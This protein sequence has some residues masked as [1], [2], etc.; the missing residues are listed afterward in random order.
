MD[1]KEKALQMGCSESNIYNRVR[2]NPNWE[3]A[4][5]VGNKITFPDSS[6]VT[7][8]SEPDELPTEEYSK[9]RKAFWDAENSKQNTIKQLRINDAESGR[10]VK[11]SELEKG[12]GA[13]LADIR[14]RVTGLALRLKREVGADLSERAEEVLERLCDELL[15]EVIDNHGVK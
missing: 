7:V 4:Q 8:V 10:L 11:R 1:V 15:K 6:P 9:R 3:G 13:V 14:K 2:E 5:K 12:F